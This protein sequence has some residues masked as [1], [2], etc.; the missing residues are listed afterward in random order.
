[1]KTLITGKG[2]WATMD[3][4]VAGPRDAKA[5]LDPGLRQGWSLLV[6]DGLIEASGAREE[7]TPEASGA[8]EVI[9]LGH[10]L[11]VP[12]LVDPHTHPVFAGTREDEFEMRILGKSYEEIAMAG[13]G[14][15]NSARRLQEA[16]RE[17][18]LSRRILQ[19][20]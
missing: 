14:I 8:D 13:G 10:L 17:T 9:D 12:G 18:L 2:P 4:G 16:R 5:L 19:D 15:R 7:L 3:T 20:A 6:R 11:V 1:M